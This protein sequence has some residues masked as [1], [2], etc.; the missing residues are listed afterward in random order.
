MIHAKDKRI[1]VAPDSFKGCLTAVEVCDAVAH[2]LEGTDISLTPMADGGEG[3]LDAIAGATGARRVEAMGVDPLGRPGRF[4][5]LLLPSGAAVIE[6]AVASGLTLLAA[7]ERN[8]LEAS[9]YG[10]GL[11]MADALRRG[12]SELMECIG[13]SATNDEIGRAHV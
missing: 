12:C 7:D 6:L 13:G 9:T 5:Y 1:V 4:G 2:G 11:L 3:T 10:T 8:P